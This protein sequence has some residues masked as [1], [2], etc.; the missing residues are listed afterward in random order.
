[1]SGGVCVCVEGPG[2]GGVGVRLVRQQGALLCCQTVSARVSGPQTVP[3]P[4]RG[5]AASDWDGIGLLPPSRAEITAGL[6]QRDIST[7]L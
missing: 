1:M 6:G 2:G 4:C 5:H 3:S 7:A